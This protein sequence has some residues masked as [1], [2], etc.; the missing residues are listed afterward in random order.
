MKKILS[1]ILALLLLCGTALADTSQVITMDT[2]NVPAIPEGTLSAEVV[3][4]TG[5][6]TYAVYS[7]PNKKSIRGA[8]GDSG[9]TFTPFVDAEGILSWSNNKGE[10]LCRRKIRI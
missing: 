4:F 6:Q 9:A 10:I 1:L 5:N 3:S 7:A 8:K 2:S